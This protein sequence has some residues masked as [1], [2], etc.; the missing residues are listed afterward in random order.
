MCAVRWCDVEVCSCVLQALTAAI[1][2][3]QDTT[4]IERLS[5]SGSHTEVVL[6]GRR[7]SATAAGQDTPD[8]GTN[9][10]KEKFNNKTG[11]QTDNA[12][13]VRKLSKDVSIR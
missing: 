13:V 6:S 7:A 11:G 1:D 3:V 2:S 4:A 8:I 9:I 5:C 12:D 10:L